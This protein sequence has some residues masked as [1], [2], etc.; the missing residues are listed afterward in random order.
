M[1]E[2]ELNVIISHWLI[3]WTQLS[4]ICHTAFPSRGYFF[5]KVMGSGETDRLVS[6]NDIHQITLWLVPDLI[7]SLVIRASCVMFHCSHNETR[8]SSEW[9]NMT[10]EAHHPSETVTWEHEADC[11]QRGVCLL[12]SHSIR[13]TKGRVSEEE[14][15]VEGV[16]CGEVR[17]PTQM[18]SPPNKRPSC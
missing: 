14:T 10:V 18:L 8:L 5:S 12:R 2:S 3:T 9:S 13:R 6:A 11:S 7:N 16:V 4:N 1:E 15:A 17:V